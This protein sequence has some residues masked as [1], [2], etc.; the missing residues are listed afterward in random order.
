MVIDDLAM[1]SPASLARARRRLEDLGLS[2]HVAR[3][4]GV[5]EDLGAEAARAVQQCLEGR[6]DLLPREE[7]EHVAR[8]RLRDVDLQRRHHCGLDVV[9]L[10]RLGVHDAGHASTAPGC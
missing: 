6:L 10:G 4:V 7:D 8:Q 2:G 9:R 5:D 3:Q 1:L